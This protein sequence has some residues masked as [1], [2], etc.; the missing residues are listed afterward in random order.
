MDF[1]FIACSGSRTWHIYQDNPDWKVPDGQAKQLADKNPEMV[2]L[3]IGG[4]DVG[5]VKL[6][7]RV[8]NGHLKSII[9]RKLIRYSAST[10]S[11]KITLMLVVG[12]DGSGL[13]TVQMTAMQLSK[14]SATILVARSSH[15]TSDKP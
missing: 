8:C 6:L 14:K 7:D 2:T 4:N 1:S 12:V 9:R 5:F 15:K 13:M 10:D 3:S 11:I